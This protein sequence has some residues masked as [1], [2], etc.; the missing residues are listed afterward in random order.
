MLTAAHV[1]I[2]LQSV[3]RAESAPSELAVLTV[4]SIRAGDASNVILDFADIKLTIRTFLPQVHERVLA[5]VH[6]IVRAECDACKFKNAAI[7]G[8]LVALADVACLHLA[9]CEH[10]PDFKDYN[11]RASNDQR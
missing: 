1:V 10:P 8:S 3:V 7:P 4:G 6:R 11:A 9:G 5:A 2:R